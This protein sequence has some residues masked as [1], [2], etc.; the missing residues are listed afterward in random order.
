ME[1]DLSLC[2]F[3]AKSLL[4]HISEAIKVLH[5]LLSRVKLMVRLMEWRSE[6]MIL[7][8]IFCD[9]VKRA[10]GCNKCSQAFSRLA[11]HNIGSSSSCKWQGSCILYTKVM[12]IHQHQMRQVINFEHPYSQVV[13]CWRAGNVKNS[14]L[15]ECLGPLA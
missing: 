4:P 8:H 15:I 1:A 5:S 12:V 13:W 11:H 10:H 14:Q 2:L 7:P 6:S 3:E 9:G